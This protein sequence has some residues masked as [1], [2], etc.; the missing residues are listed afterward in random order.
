[1]TTFKDFQ[2]LHEDLRDTLVYHLTA[3]IKSVSKDY[4]VAKEPQGEQPWWTMTI[5]DLFRIL[6][7]E[8]FLSMAR[9]WQDCGRDMMRAKLTWTEGYK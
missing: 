2:D 5:A 1:M 7:N 8:A 3:K 4:L 6:E 9:C